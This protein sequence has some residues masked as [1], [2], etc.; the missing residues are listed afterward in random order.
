VGTGGRRIGIGMGIVAIVTA[1]LPA[2]PASLALEL[3][4]VTEKT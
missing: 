2:L 1:A 3:A 4:P